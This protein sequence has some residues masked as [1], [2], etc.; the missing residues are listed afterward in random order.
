MAEQFECF[1]GDRFADR[2]ELI[3]HNV[4]E[5]DMTETESRRR[6]NEKYPLEST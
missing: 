4:A 5:H 2:D 3:Q 1:C 6:V